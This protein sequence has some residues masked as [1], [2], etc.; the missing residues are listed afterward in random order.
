MKTSKN[1]KNNNSKTENGRF[2]C[3]NWDAEVNVHYHGGHNSVTRKVVTKGQWHVNHEAWPTIVNEIK[4]HMRMGQIVYLGTD[5]IFVPVMKKDLT[6]MYASARAMGGLYACLEDKK[7]TVKHRGEILDEEQCEDMVEEQNRR[8][9]KSMKAS[10]T[11]DTMVTCP[12]C[13]TEFRVGKQL[14]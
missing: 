13:G 12:N 1:A 10:V 8:H 6:G 9:E 4:K 5:L 3:D 14:M 2:V 7:A 11:P